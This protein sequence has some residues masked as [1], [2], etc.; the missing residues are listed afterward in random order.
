VHAG[1]KQGVFVLS[2]DDGYPC[3]TTIIA[4]E[5]A[6]VGGVATGFVNN[7]RIHSRTMSFDDLR[8]LQNRY[9]WEIGT[10]TY[11]H[12]DPTIY[13]ELHDV[14]TWLKQELD[15]SISDF[16]SQGLTIR[17]LV[18][19][20]N[21]YTD[22]L[23]IEAL[24]RVENFRQYSMRPFARG[25]EKDGSVPA[26][27]IDLEHYVPM[28]MI[29]QWIDT[30]HEKNLILL[31]YGHK[32]LPDKHFTTG[33]VASVTKHTL[34]SKQKIKNLPDPYLCLVPD[35]RKPLDFAFMVKEIKGNTVHIANGDLTRVSE[36]GAQFM[37]GPCIGM[38]L[39]DFRS[40]IEYA[41]KRLYFRTVHDALSNPSA[42]Q[43]INQSSRPS[44]GDTIHLKSIR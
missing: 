13:I 42:R 15:A 33:K 17:S 1:E 9:G 5:L 43:E 8:S 30:A 6:R 16:Q 11:N 3:W 36:P 29:F 38:R 20:F 25:K 34:V 24:K 26:K 4:P 14:S 23:R 19:P 28:K 40:M 18:F 39:S 10:H 37:I 41:G 2:F 31:L 44:T 12:Y 21:K 35:K 32:V 22:E 7:F 27:S